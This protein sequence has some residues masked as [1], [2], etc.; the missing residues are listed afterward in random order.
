MFTD[1][2]QLGGILGVASTDPVTMEYCKN[3]GWVKG[4]DIVGG[5]VGS[6]NNSNGVTIYSCVNISNVTSDRGN[7]GSI[8]GKRDNDYSVSTSNTFYNSSLY[9]GKAA[10]VPSSLTVTDEHSFFA[11]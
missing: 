5:L 7:V 4:K 1:Y 9:S 10:R 11:T 3:A 6:F 2:T 8:I